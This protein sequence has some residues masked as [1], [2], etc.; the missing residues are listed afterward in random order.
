MKNRVGPFDV[1]EDFFGR[2]E[3]IRRFTELLDAGEHVSLVA[4]R[5]TGKTSL[6]HEASRHLKDRLVCL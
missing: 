3:E 5:R 6:L 2:D 1:A 4:Q